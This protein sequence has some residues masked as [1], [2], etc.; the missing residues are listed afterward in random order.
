MGKARVSRVCVA[1]IAAAHGVGGQLRVKSFTERPEDLTA[2]GPL[3]DAHGAQRIELTLSGRS[4]GHFL[5]RIAG[6]ETRTQAQALAGTRLYIA[7]AALPALED[8]ESY[9]HADLIGLRVEDRNGKPLGRIA[10][11]YNHGAGDLLEIEAPR[12]ETFLVPFTKAAV[13][14]VDIDAGR[15][16]VDQP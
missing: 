7:R 1:V 11:L 10:A 3:T 2:Y 12:G 16:V 4:K 6:V 13:P 15:L 8:S 14:L 9:Y 5:A